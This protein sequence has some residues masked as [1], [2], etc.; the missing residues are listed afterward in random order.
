MWTLEG[1]RHR[2]IKRCHFLRNIQ[3]QG[4]A[5]I[6]LMTLGITIKE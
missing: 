4:D 3:I 1:P 2:S 6:S 5:Q